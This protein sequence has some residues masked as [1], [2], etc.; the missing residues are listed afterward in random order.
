[1][2]TCLEV[3]NQKVGLLTTQLEET[4]RLTNN[5]KSLL[6]SKESEM[7][8]MRNEYKLFKNVAVVEQNRLI[9]CLEESKKCISELKNQPKDTK[10][11][12]HQ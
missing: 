11:N 4:K 1:M 3:S 7:E 2:R 5:L 6:D 8:N 12:E 9:R 10:D